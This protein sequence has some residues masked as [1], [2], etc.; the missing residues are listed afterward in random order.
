MLVAGDGFLFHFDFSRGIVMINPSQQPV[1][2]F[3]VFNLFV[4]VLSNTRKANAVAKDITLNWWELKFKLSVKLEP[5]KVS[6][7]K[8]KL[9]K[10][11]QSTHV[12]TTNEAIEIHTEVIVD[13]SESPIMVSELVDA[14]KQVSGL[15]SAA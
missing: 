8:D 12:V 4:E 5:E 11:F 9:S 6:A 7:I 3:D 15:K 14:F 2:T 10:S 13:D 1:R